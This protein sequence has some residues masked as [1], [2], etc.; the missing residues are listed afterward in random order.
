MA[1]IDFGSDYDLR[2]K[3]EAKRLFKVTTTDGIIRFAKVVVLGIGAGGKPNMPRELSAAEKEGACHSTQLPKQVFLAP[4]MMQKILRRAPTAVMIVGG[5][6]TAAQ[7][8]NQC[9]ENG[10]SHV[11]MVLRSALKR[12]SPVKEV[13]KDHGRRAYRFVHSKTVRY[14]SRLDG[15][16]S[17]RAESRVLVC[18]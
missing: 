8:A 18:R 5:G 14:R 12:T 11:F 1:S 4:R 2:H 15:E 13:I 6:L 3:D 17:E 7:I 9:I 16:I 10:V